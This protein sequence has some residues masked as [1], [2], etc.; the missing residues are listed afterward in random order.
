MFIGSMFFGSEMV[1]QD[2]YRFLR[3][4]R[5]MIINKRIIMLFS[6]FIGFHIFVIRFIHETSQ[7]RIMDNGIFSCFKLIDSL[8]KNP[9]RFYGLM[10]GITD[11]GKIPDIRRQSIWRVKIL[12]AGLYIMHLHRCFGYLFI[13]LHAFI[14]GTE[15]IQWM[16][17][18]FI[19]PIEQITFFI[20]DFWIQITPSV[21]CIHRPDKPS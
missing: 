19:Q 18:F 1:L 15:L 9:V 7:F 6:V 4:V 16:E 13:I 17:R 8:A 2:R 14:P 10:K 3:D 21:T 12:T 5:I 20:V 11:T